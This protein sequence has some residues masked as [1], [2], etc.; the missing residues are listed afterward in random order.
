MC[1]VVTMHGQPAQAT[2]D[3][4]YHSIQSR[5]EN[6]TVVTADWSIVGICHRVRQRAGQGNEPT[7]VIE[8]GSALN[9]EMSVYDWSSTR[10]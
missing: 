6:I 1:Y 5:F 7:I 4:S 9:V 10:Y 2:V 3:L 8:A